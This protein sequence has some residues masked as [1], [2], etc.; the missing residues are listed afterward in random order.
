MNSW[1][2]F[3]MSRTGYKKNSW[4]K[5]VKTSD[6]FIIRLQWDTLVGVNSKILDQSFFQHSNFA[7]FKCQMVEKSF[8]GLLYNFSSLGTF[9]QKWSCSRIRNFSKWHPLNN[10][11]IIMLIGVSVKHL[12]LKSWLKFMRS[13]WSKRLEGTKIFFTTACLFQSPA[14]YGS[15][16]YQ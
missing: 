15:D 14:F 8:M 9:L 12:S 10:I 2:R 13:L 3:L 5:L 1:F 4:N 11:E 7:N 16:N 6:E